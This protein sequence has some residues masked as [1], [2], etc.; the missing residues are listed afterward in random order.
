MGSEKRKRS[1]AGRDFLNLTAEGTLNAFRSCKATTEVFCRS[2]GAHKTAICCSLLEKITEIFAGTPKRAILTAS[3]QLLR[4]GYSKQ[5]GTLTILVSLLQLLSMVKSRFNQSKAPNLRQTVS[6]A[7]SHRLWTM[8]TS[9]TKRSRNPKAPALIF[10][11]HPSG[12]RDPAVCHSAL[13]G[14]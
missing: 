9:S 1:G 11:K 10:R 8:M 2:P 12:Y 5:D 7:A 3:F 14:K 4:T 13:G 6:L